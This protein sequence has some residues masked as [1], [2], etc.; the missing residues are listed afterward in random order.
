MCA[1]EV[2]L[3]KC[4][5]EVTSHHS[6]AAMLLNGCESSPLFGVLR[7]SCP[8]CGCAPCF[9]TSFLGIAALLYVR[10]HMLVDHQ[11]IVWCAAASSRYGGDR[12]LI[13]F[14][15]PNFANLS[16]LLPC[17]TPTLRPTTSSSTPCAPCPGPAGSRSFPACERP[18]V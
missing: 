12:R 13:R 3:A 2:C 15:K 11:G 18:V 1:C 4:K 16:P 6:A 9:S 5:G 14:G 7:L 10:G 8:L 17:S